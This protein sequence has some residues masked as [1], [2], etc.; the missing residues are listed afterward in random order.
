M[1]LLDLKPSTVFLDLKHPGTGL[2]LGVRCE[3]QSMQSDAVKAVERTLKNKALRGGRNNVTAEKIDDNT[4]LILAA[5]LVGWEFYQ[6]VL[7][8]E[9]IIPQ[10]A[11]NGKEV[12]DRVI[13]AVLGEVP[14]IDGDTKPPCSQANKVKLMS[15]AP[16]AKQVDDILGDDTLF[17]VS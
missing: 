16:L 7:Q 10:P 1:N 2:P 14:N 6:P 5:A 9:Q 17:F 11:V 4:V 12:P 8:A 3:L 13:P 15:V